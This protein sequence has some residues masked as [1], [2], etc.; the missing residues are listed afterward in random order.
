MLFS[1]TFCLLSWLWLF[2]FLLAAAFHT[3][4]YTLLVNHPSERIWADASLPKLN[5]VPVLLTLPSSTMS[6]HTLISLVIHPMRPPW[7]PYSSEHFTSIQNHWSQ[8][9]MLEVGKELFLMHQLEVCEGWVVIPGLMLL[10]ASEREKCGQVCRIYF[11]IL[12]TGISLRRY[13]GY[14]Q[15]QNHEKA[16]RWRGW[17]S[18]CV[19]HGLILCLIYKVYS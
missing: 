16:L 1:L 17:A 4:P 18:L 7:K 12:S 8:S 10:L 5:R 6:P 15:T 19:L 11:V 9:L 14:I 3:L 2:A 13:H